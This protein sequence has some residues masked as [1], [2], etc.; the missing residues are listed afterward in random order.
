MDQD[1]VELVIFLA[2]LLSEGQVTE[3]KREQL[4]KQARRLAKKFDE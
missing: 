4:I 3:K 2:L 1:Q